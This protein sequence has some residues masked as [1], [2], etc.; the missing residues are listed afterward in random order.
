MKKPVRVIHFN[1]KWQI[2]RQGI[3]KPISEHL[4]QGIAIAKAR[5][6]AKK[7]KVELFIHARDGRIRAR[8]S[9]GHDPYPPK[10]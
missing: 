10:G 1:G 3:H 2:R 7:E 9:Y 6:V 8:D 4:I 5:H